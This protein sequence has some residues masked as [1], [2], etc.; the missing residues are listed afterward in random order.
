MFTQILAIV[1]VLGVIVLIHEWGHF[2]SARSIGIAV[3]EFAVGL[4]PA[5]WKRQGK[6]TLY[7][8]RC[9]PFGGYCLFNSEL[10]GEDR[11]GRPLSIVNRKALSKAYICVAGPVMN[12]LLAAVLF[13]VVFSFIGVPVAYE[14]VIGEVQPDSPAAEGGMLPGDRVLSIGGEALESW[15][16]LSRVLAA[17]RNEESVEFHI[18]RGAEGLILEVKPRLN[19]EE[20]RV[21]IG[22]I[23]DQRR[24][25]V[26]KVSPWRG[27]RLGLSQTFIMMG[28]LLEA[29]AHMA[30]GRISVSENISG[31]VALAQ[32]IMETASTGLSN[33]LFLTAFLSV[34]LG[35]MNLLPLP[36]LDGGKIIMYAVELIRR[37]PLKLEVE[38]WINVV[39]FVLLISLM[40]ILTFKDIFQLFT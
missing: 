1:F 29:I 20:D 10:E 22:V 11:K 9:I 19:E 30:T 14:A 13:T 28:A 15:S 31:P 34:N 35:I 8:V 32:V 40:V 4:G 24:A 21:L 36:A 25:V 5:I 27:V 6:S 3:Q 23:V 17:Y 39:G 33:T 16:D 7:S 2:I 26:E 37:K 12:F 38:G 18:Q